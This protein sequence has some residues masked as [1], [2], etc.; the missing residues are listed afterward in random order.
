[1]AAS[2]LVKTFCE[3]IRILKI[4][5]EAEIQDHTYRQEQLLFKHRVRPEN[6]PAPEIIAAN[7]EQQEEH[8]HAA[9]LKIKE[10]AYG[11]QVGGS[12][13][14]YLVNK[15][16]KEQDNRKESPEEQVC[17]QQWFILRI[18]DYVIY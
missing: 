6:A 11:Q 13:L 5:Q 14:V 3:E 1:M 16:I 17:K 15:R 12:Q 10:K 2:D 18:A 9:G 8:E 4:A 7:S